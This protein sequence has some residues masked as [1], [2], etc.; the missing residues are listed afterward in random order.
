VRENG[1]VFHTYR[2]VAPYFNFLLER[3]PKPQPPEPR[4]WRR[5]EYPD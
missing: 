3:T 2:F 5:D 1:T 4:A